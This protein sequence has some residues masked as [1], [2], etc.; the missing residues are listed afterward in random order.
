ML[1]K[2]IAFLFSFVLIF[3]LAGCSTAN[4]S[5]GDLLVP[6]KPSGEMYKIQKALEKAVKSNVKLK[7]P[8]S[9]EYRSAFIIKN[10]KGESEQDYCIALYAV[11]EEA[12]QNI[13]INVI[14]KNDGEWVSLHDTYFAAS[15]VEMIDFHDFTGDGVLEIIVGFNVYSGVDKQ[16]AVYS[17]E[18]DSIVT[19]LLEPYDHFLFTDLNGD[20]E[21]EVFVLNHDAATQSAT[22]RLFTFNKNGITELGSCYLDGSISSYYP[23][24]ETTLAN[25]QP[26][27]LVDAIKGKGLITEAIFI[28]NNNLFAPFINEASGQNILTQR[29]NSVSCKDIN[30]D[31]RLDIPTLRP[32]SG[33]TGNDVSSSYIT[34]WVNYNGKDIFTVAHTIMN[35]IDG[36]YLTLPEKYVTSIGINRQ[37]EARQRTF[38]IW[39]YEENVPETEL[40]TIMVVAVDDWKEMSASS[41]YFELAN[42]SGYV[43]LGKIHK[44]TDKDKESIT[45]EELQKMFNLIKG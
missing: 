5:K 16:V 6:P 2:I 7:Y 27:I 33:V 32:I 10:L 21:K 28:K 18:K 4:L 22:A 34:S 11:G 12:T 23:P 38:Y 43:Y 36:Y 13:H 3:S 35:Y 24:T 30:G 44:S 9:G 41:G 39:N 8:T 25:G 45:Q 37:T 19:R 40:F 20:K 14:K 17:L 26:A 15:D 29:E 31:G 42:D 1:K